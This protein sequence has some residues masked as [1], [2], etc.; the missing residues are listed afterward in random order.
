MIGDSCQIEKAEDIRD[1]FVPNFYFGCEA[2]DPLNATAFNRKMNPFGAQLR[3]IFSSDI[4]HWDVPDMTEVLEEAYELVED[5]VITEEDF[6]DFVFTNP[7]SLWAGMN[8][9]FFKGTVVETAT[10]QAYHERRPL[11]ILSTT[12]QLEGKPIKDYRG[13]VTGEAIVGANIFKDFFAGIRDIVGGRSAAYEQ[14]LQKAR[15][16]AFK[17]LEEAAQKLGANA[18]VGIDIDYE[19]VGQNG[20]MLMVSVSGTAVII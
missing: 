11:M 19:V 6:R 18:I 2:D 4:G 12:S 16:I 8:P 9:D 7:V 17:E 20:S 5:E 3:A 1:L 15:E 13:I 14:E 10:A